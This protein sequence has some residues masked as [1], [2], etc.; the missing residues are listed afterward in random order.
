MA[1]A[2]GALTTSLF[3]HPHFSLSSPPLRPNADS[4][5]FQRRHRRRDRHRAGNG[6]GMVPSSPAQL[7]HKLKHPCYSGGW[8]LI[9]GILGQSAGR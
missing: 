4:R 2:A 1:A 6:G 7:M 8:R 5:Y 9:L 3:F